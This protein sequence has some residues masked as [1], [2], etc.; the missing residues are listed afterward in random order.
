MSTPPTAPRPAGH[1]VYRSVNRPLTI[2]GADRRLAFL[3]LVM[4]A[5]T[6]TFA[7]SALAGILMTSVL[8]GAARWMTAHDVQLLRIVLR[9]STTRHHYDPAKLAHVRVIPASAAGPRGLRPANQPN[10]AH[11][12]AL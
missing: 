3:A 11:V 2:G 6:F 9:S 10:P 12:S 5:A 7:N 4:G 1:P 8:W